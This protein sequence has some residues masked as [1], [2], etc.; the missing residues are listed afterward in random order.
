MSRSIQLST[1]RDRHQS[2]QDGTVA[3]DCLSTLTHEEY[4]QDTEGCNLDRRRRDTARRTFA[5]K[6]EMSVLAT[7]PG[8]RARAQAQTRT[9]EHELTV[10][11]LRACRAQRPRGEPLR[12][13]DTCSQRRNTVRERVRSRDMSRG[14]KVRTGGHSLVNVPVVH[15]LESCRDSHGRR[16]EDEY[17]RVEPHAER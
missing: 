13:V 8:Q 14:S 11:A 6:V 10:Q 17:N 12:L 2:C 7:M 3:W 5:V 15:V 16:R 4:E 1:R 9:N